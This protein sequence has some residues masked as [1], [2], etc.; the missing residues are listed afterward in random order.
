[1][2]FYDFLLSSPPKILSQNMIIIADGGS[3]KCDWVFL[4][5]TG[6]IRSKTQTAG[7]NPNVIDT[8]TIPSE[9]AQNAE[10]FE[11][12]FKIK[13]IFF[14]GSGCGLEENQ[15]KVKTALQTF[16]PNAHILVKSDLTAAAYSAYNGSPAIV[17]ILGT[18]SN[19]C[20]FDGENVTTK[21]PSLGFLIGDDGSG[22]ALGKNLVKN[23]F[24]K[25]LPPDLHQ[26][27]TEKYSLKI[28]DLIRNM[29]HNPK[30]NAYLASFNTFIYENKKHPY[31]Q[32]L[33]FQE[34]K[35]YF[36]YQVLPYEESRESEINFIGSIAFLYEDILK[37]AAAEFNLKV[38]QIVQKPIKNLILYH[39]NYIFEDLE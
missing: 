21:I 29:Y 2:F 7:M 10:L 12:R 19:S 24:M 37:A 32:N 20:Y 18:G 36:D 15:E 13:H 4:D 22:C 1:M 26:L 17:C 39:K 28:E 34:F 35:N 33:I 14:Y 6:N 25:K 8:T 38:G 27:F 30:A 23:Y 3:T 11:K 31:I 5:N 16:F 9:L